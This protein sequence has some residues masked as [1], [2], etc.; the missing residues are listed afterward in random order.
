MSNAD[1]EALYRIV[2]YPIIYIG[3]SPYFDAI[4]RIY[5]GKII[6]KN[7][8]KPIFLKKQRLYAHNLYIIFC[9]IPVIIILAIYLFS[10]IG[11]VFIFSLLGIIIDIPS[12]SIIC[13]IIITGIIV[14][15]TIAIPFIV[16][17]G[18]SLKLGRIRISETELKIIHDGRE[19]HYLFSDLIGISLPHFPVFQELYN[20]ERITF[21][22]FDLIIL[23]FSNGK[24]VLLPS[25]IKEY[26]LFIFFLYKNILSKNGE[27]RLSERFEME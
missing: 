3:A 1:Y 11:Y 16:N 13:F 17:I 2:D 20:N 23:A 18:L 6:M 26:T 14:F 5:R 21:N 4:G 9:A 27:I 24:I 10:P 12:I 25:T 8:Q 19:C 15:Y 22:K 7:P